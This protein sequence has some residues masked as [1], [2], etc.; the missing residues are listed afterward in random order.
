MKVLELLKQ[1]RDHHLA[2]HNDKFIIKQY[3]E[4]IVELET[5]GIKKAIYENILTLI[6]I[7][8]RK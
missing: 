6:D 3:D 4:A 7:E 8:C 1:E 5:Y 2:V